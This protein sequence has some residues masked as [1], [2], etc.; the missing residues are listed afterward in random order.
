[1]YEERFIQGVSRSN[2][3]V[4]VGHGS[5]RLITKV[6]VSTMSKFVPP[7]AVIYVSYAPGGS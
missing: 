6:I 1:M 7:V 2:E 3:S 4:E 5:T